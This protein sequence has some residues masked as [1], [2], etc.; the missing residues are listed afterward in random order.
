MSSKLTVDIN[1]NSRHFLKQDDVCR[2][3]TTRGC[4]LIGGHSGAAVVPSSDNYSSHHLPSIGDSRPILR[5]P[6]KRRINLTPDESGDHTGVSEKC[7]EVFPRFPKADLSEWRGQ[8][9][10]ARYDATVFRP[11]VISS[12]STGVEPVGVQFEGMD[13]ILQVSVC[14]SCKLTVF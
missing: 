13:E 5:P 3:I 8:R 7:T 4:S 11:A 12:I 1:R 14:F 10:L 6:K 9:V 2:Y